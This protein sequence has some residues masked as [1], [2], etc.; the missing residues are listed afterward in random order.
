M[1]DVPSKHIPQVFCFFFTFQEPA[2]SR[3]CS[4][5]YGGAAGQRLEPWRG[6]RAGAGDLALCLAALLDDLVGLVGGDYGHCS[7]SGEVQTPTGR[8]LEDGKIR[9]DG[10]MGGA[11]KGRD[12]KSSGDWKG[13]V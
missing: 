4:R 3:P 7:E 5:P 1:K 9:E 12:F 6:L 2:L 8:R 11:G 10:K 13:W